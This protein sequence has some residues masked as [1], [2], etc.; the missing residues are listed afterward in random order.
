MS[1]FLS[2]INLNVNRLIS[3]LKHTTKPELKK[4]DPTMGSHRRLSLDSR[5]H[6]MLKLKQM[7]RDM[8]CKWETNGTG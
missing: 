2:I 3:P 4:K 5:T 8:S 6:V 1:P 7:E